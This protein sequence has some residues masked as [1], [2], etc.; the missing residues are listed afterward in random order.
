MEVEQVLEHPLYWLCDITIFPK[1]NI[2][3]KVSPAQSLGK[4][5]NAR[6]GYRKT[7]L[8]C[9]SFMFLWPCIV[10]KA[11]G[12][13]T[14]K[15]QQYWCLL[16]IVDVDYWH[17]LNMFRASLCPSSGERPRVTACGVYLLVSA[18]CGRLRYCGATLRVWSLWRLLF[19]SV[20]QQPSQWSLT[21]KYTPHAVTRDLSPEDGHKDARNMLRQ[22]Q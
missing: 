10:S 18:G 3:F 4:K 20:E 22:C 15:M 8:R 9:T 17:C 13:K 5:H 12:K 6:Q 14:N 16:S 7:V 2:C 19:D 1:P 21:S 11:W